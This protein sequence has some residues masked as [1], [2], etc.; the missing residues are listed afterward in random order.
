MTVVYSTFWGGLKLG[1]RSSHVH[2]LYQEARWFLNGLSQELEN[3]VLYNFERSYPD[4]V[5][6]IGQET[7]IQ[8]MLP[9]SDGLKVIRYYL[10]FSRG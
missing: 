9:T 10:I 7:S 2:E 3:M 8:L 5:A 6:F 1:Q 4:K